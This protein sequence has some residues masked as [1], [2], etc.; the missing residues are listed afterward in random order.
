[1]PMGITKSVP[2]CGGCDDR[3][4]GCHSNCDKYKIYRDSLDK[5]NSVCREAKNVNNN[6]DRYSV[7]TNR[8]MNKKK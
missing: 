4:I 3:T 7:D 6:I 1:M 2:P 8:R 5:F